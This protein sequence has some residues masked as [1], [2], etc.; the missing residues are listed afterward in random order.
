MSQYLKSSDPDVDR[1]QIVRAFEALH[2]STGASAFF[3][4]DQWWI[5]EP[6]SNVYWS[7]HDEYS[8]SFCLFAGY[9]FEEICGGHDE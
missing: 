8:D 5:W 4:H 1:T 9:G 3:E 7:V 6:E 2:G